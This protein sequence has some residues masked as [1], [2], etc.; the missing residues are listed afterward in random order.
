MPFFT[1]FVYVKSQHK[2]GRKKYEKK[3]N[4]LLFQY[5][6]Q[7]NNKKKISLKYD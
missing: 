7:F 1:E 3:L 5:K 2:K 6:L 4:S